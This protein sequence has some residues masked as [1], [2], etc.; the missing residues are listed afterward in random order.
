MR[1]PEIR[2]SRGLALTGTAI[3][4]TMALACTRGSAPAETA[5]GTIYTGGDGRPSVHMP[6]QRP[7]DQGVDGAVLVNLALLDPRHPTLVP[8]HSE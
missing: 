4:L 6:A 5:E 2:A 3:A 1:L 8:R 7:S